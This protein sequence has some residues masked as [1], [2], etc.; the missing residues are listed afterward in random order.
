MALLVVYLL[1]AVA[2]GYA[3]ARLHGALTRSY[4]GWTGVAVRLTSSGECC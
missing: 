2:A 1:L 4:D 3:A